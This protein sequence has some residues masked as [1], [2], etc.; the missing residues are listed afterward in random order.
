MK[1]QKILRELISENKLSESDL[2][3]LLKINK[4]ETELRFRKRILGGELD[5]IE[6]DEQI[7]LL[8]TFLKS[9]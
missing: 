1:S 6:N 5:P 3:Y 4:F 9:I 8:E 7:M 2:N